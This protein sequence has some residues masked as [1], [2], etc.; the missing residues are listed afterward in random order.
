VKVKFLDIG[1][2]YADNK[3]FADFVDILHSIDKGDINMTTT[4]KAM[5]DV[6][7]DDHKWQVFRWIFIPYIFYLCLTL[8]YMVNVIYGT[9]DDR[10][11]W[12]T[13]IGILNLLS[14]AYLLY[15]EY[16]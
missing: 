7:W 3:V 1:W 16:L 6:F 9:D 13:Y 15:N 12:E 2:L 8:Y 14:V 4:V 10:N 5:L 11:G